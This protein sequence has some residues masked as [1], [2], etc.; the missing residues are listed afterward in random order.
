MKSE[1]IKGQDI[2]YANL[3]GD[4]ESMAINLVRAMNETGVKKLIFIS[5]INK[6][7]QIYNQ[8]Y[9]ETRNVCSRK[10]GNK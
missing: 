9:C 1:A 10:F 3:A 2:V 7:S 4:L 5:S 6:F 8:N